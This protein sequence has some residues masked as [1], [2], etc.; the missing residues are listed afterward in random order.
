[1]LEGVE[2]LFDLAETRVDL[3]GQLVGFGIFGFE[4]VIFVAQRLAVARSSVRSTVMP[5]SSRSHAWP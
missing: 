1:V 2:R 4:P 3:V 5:A